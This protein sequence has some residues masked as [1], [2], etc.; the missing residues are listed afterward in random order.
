MRSPTNTP[1]DALIKGSGS[2]SDST[3]PAATIVPTKQPAETEALRSDRLVPGIHHE[4]PVLVPVALTASRKASAGFLLRS[5]GHD[6]DLLHLKLG[7]QA[8]AFQIARMPRG[9][10]FGLGRWKLHLV[11]VVLALVEP[12]HDAAEEQAEG[13]AAEE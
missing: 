11:L 8:Q 10:Q 6:L 4:M 3:G 13:A 5:V 7:L 9:F 12:V 1:K 2:N